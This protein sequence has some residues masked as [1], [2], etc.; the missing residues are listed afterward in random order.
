MGKIRR[1]VTGHD[2]TG[3]AVFVDDRYAPVVHTISGRPGF[4]VNE[5]W[6]TAGAPATLGDNPDMTAGPMQLAPPSRGTVF[7]ILEIPPETPETRARLAENP[8]ATFA[9]LGGQGASTHRADAPH[10]MMHRTESI[11]YAIVLTG[12]IYLILDDSET[13][14]RQGDVVI[15]CG[16]SH[17]WSNRSSTPCRIAFVLVD[18]RFS[19]ELARKLRDS[20]AV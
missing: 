3:K 7:R 1:V 10:P 16:T 15:Q 13:L 5:L 4:W 2:K 6:K 8:Q 20:S 12:E 19:D 9:A 11:D 18:A 17:A 14:I